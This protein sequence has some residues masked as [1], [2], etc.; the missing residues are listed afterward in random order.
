ML[1]RVLANTSTAIVG[2]EGTSV[3]SLRLLVN[4]GCKVVKTCD[5]L[6]SVT[7]QVL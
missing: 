7:S 4:A 1:S 6:T 3:L 5:V 2:E